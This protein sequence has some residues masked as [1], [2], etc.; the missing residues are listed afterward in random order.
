ML[1]AEQVNAYRRDG[2]TVH[3][4]LLSAEEVADLLGHVASICAGN[5]LANHDADRLEMEPDQP[6]DGTRVRRLYEPC[7]YH[8]RFTELSISRALLDCVEQLLGP[9]ILFHYS[10]LNMKP[11]EIGSVVEWHQ[12]LAYYPLTNRDSLAVLFYLDDT[13]SDNGCLRVIPGRQNAEVLTHAADPFFQGRITEPLDDSAALDVSGR[14]GSAIF[15][16]CMTPHASAVNRSQRPRRTLI[17]SYRAADAFPIYVGDAT[18]AAE[19]KVQLVR[20]EPQRSARFTM[21]E[22]PVPV[23]KG[24]AA[25]S[26]YDLQE[27]SREGELA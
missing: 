8:P 17:L 15:M 16:H 3:E 20:G 23:Y 7:T 4:D 2:F 1:S 19:S 22:F 11:A 24:G 18:H 13:D 27:R 14:A 21:R 9:N 12:D 5:S 25:K 6:P 10:K 26:L